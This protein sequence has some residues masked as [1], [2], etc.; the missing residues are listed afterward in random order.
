MGFDHNKAGIFWDSE[1]CSA[2]LSLSG[3]D[4][5]QYIQKI[6]LI[7]GIIKS[8]KAYTQISKKGLSRKATKQRIQLRDSGVSVIDCPHGDRKNAVDMMIIADIW[9]FA[10][11]NPPSLS[12]TTTIIIVSGDGDYSY[13]LSSL[14][15]RGYKIIVVAPSQ[16]HQ[17]IREQATM[18]FSWESIK[19]KVRQ[20]KNVVQVSTASKAGSDTAKLKAS[21]SIDITK[22][23]SPSQTP[24]TLGSSSGSSSRSQNSSG[25]SRASKTRFEG[26]SSSAKVF[27]AF[28]W[29][30]TSPDR[31]QT[32]RNLNMGQ[33]GGTNSVRD[34][35]S[36]PTA[37]LAFAKQSQGGVGV[38][39][40]SPPCHQSNSPS[41]DALTPPPPRPRTAETMDPDSNQESESTSDASASAIRVASAGSN[42]G[43]S[44]MEKPDLC[45]MS[46]SRIDSLMADGDVMSTPVNPTSYDGDC[47]PCIG[48]TMEARKEGSS[49]GGLLSLPPIPCTKSPTLS[50]C[51][52]AMER[53]FESAPLLP[54]TS[55]IRLTLE[56]WPLLACSAAPRQS[57]SPE[58]VPALPL[59]S[60][61]KPKPESPKRL[62]KLNKKDSP[63][64]LSSCETSV[65]RPPESAP[66]LP[67][68]SFIRPTSEEQPVLAFSSASSLSISP[69]IV[70][71]LPSALE[72]KSKPKSPK[73]LP[74]LNKEDSPLVP[75]P[76]APPVDD[77]PQY[78][79]PLVQHLERRRLLNEYMP[80][81][82]K[83]ASALIE[84]DKEMYQKA[85]CNKFKDFAAKAEQMGLVTL[86]GEGRIKL[87]SEFYGKVGV[88]CQ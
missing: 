25:F 61:V 78:F 40:P 71:A 87:R 65:E 3:Y 79:F 88:K 10:M 5:A 6:G 49:S 31:L 26:K 24:R 20:T 18:L 36:S 8:F 23:L 11:D 28:N 86:G 22:P 33:R 45:A 63:P 83:V 56:E 46:Q 47:G 60:E 14:R 74:K 27:S 15:G 64:L 19:K 70:P 72:V 13:T 50:L 73:R 12:T 58:F 52:T 16:C 68:T 17:S 69:E 57:A 59:A 1:N 80:E 76:R 38:A 29:S 43:V 2:P 21:A 35:P 77:I 39:R 85:G 66:P 42:C 67:K 30:V 34:S 4:I 32:W 41:L 53:S 75:P 7:S 37:P 51:E 54:T 81:K 48:A 9:A 62:P 82:S 84:R 55:P 44:E